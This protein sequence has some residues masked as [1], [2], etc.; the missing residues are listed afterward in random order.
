SAHGETQ[1]GAGS[2]E[3]RLAVDAW[4][5]FTGP[6]GERMRLTSRDALTVLK[7]HAGA[8]DDIL[9]SR[10]RENQHD[11]ATRATVPRAQVPPQFR[12]CFRWRWIGPYK[13]RIGRQR[14]AHDHMMCIA[15]RAVLQAEMV[16]DLLSRGRTGRYAHSKRDDRCGRIGR[17]QHD[18]WRR[19]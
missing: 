18:R 1:L 17:R 11:L 12:F 15:R 7:L 2:T 6:T 8:V 16:L 3:R 14:I 9:R 5:A 10:R 13:L 4:H 19:R